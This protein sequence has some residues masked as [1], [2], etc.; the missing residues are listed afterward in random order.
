MAHDVALYLLLPFWVAML[1][2]MAVDF[3]RFEGK[4]PATRC[5]GSQATRAPKNSLTKAGI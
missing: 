3:H 1:G 2:F 4:K 5:N